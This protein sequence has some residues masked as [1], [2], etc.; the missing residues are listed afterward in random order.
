[1]FQTCSFLLY[2]LGLVGTGLLKN[3][4]SCFD[5]I[6]KSYIWNNKF[7]K[8]ETLEKQRSQTGLPNI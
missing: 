6:Q 7:Y 3:G 5:I 1:M 2:E 8:S 4:N